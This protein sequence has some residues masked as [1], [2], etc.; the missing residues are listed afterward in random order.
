[1]IAIRN[2]YEL[3]LMREAGRIVALVLQEMKHLVAPG[4]TT[5]ELDRRALEVIREHGATA[6]FLGY[7]G[8]PASLC[9]SV[10]EEVV[11]GIPGERILAAGNIV[12]ID[13]GVYHQGY[14]ADAAVTLPV[15]EIPTEWARLLQVTATS[16]EQGIAAAQE[17]NRIYDI[18][19]AVQAWVE[20][21]G[22]S[23]VR[24]LCGHGVGSSLHEAPDVPNFVSTIKGP[25]LQSGM[26]LAIEPM[27]NM[28]KAQVYTASNQWTVVAADGLPSAHFEH[29]I[30]ITPQ[31]AQI[32]TLP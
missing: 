8:F 5:G 1:M 24:D 6:S 23:V 19:K 10:N 13:V 31:G 25:R 11:H 3:S 9:V 20:A 22:F 32:L 15:G 16:L 2:N 21:A 26:V 18:A 14:H 17:G 28:G 7:R 29:T 4:V 12:S 30:A 27:V